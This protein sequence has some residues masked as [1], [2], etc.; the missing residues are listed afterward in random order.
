M[1][2]LIKRAGLILIFGLMVQNL[3]SQPFFGGYYQTENSFSIDEYE[4]INTVSFYLENSLNDF[5][6]FYTRLTLG[7]KF[8]ASWTAGTSLDQ[9]TFIPSL[10]LMYFEFKTGKRALEATLKKPGKGEANFDLFFFRL[11]R[12]PL[13]TDYSFLMDMNGDGMDMSFFHQNLRVRLFGITNS[14]NYMPL[15]DFADSSSRPVFTNWDR[16]RLPPLT[17]LSKDGNTSGFISDIGTDEYNFYFDNALTADYSDAEKERLNRLRVLGMFAGRVFTGVSFDLIQVY[18]QTFS[19]SFLANIDLIP[20]DFVVTFPSEISYGLNTFGGRYT[21]FY[22][23]FSAQGKIVKG[24]FYNFEGVYETGMNATLL[25]DD[26]KLFYRYDLINSFALSGGLS[27]FFEHVTRPSLSLNLR[28]AHGDEDARFVN[29]AI[30]NQS[31]QD[32]NFRSPSHE[33]ISYVMEPEFQ[34]L[35]VVELKN[36]IKPLSALKNDI[37]SRFLIE[38]GV[39]LILRPLIKGST[40]LAERPEYQEGGVSYENPEKVYLGTEIDIN[41]G[42]QF[43]SD[44]SVQLKTGLLI[45]N[46]AIYPEQEVIFKAGLIAVLSF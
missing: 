23:T 12:I 43:T 44:L 4:S 34:N 25:G 40:F 41:A 29:K 14:F 11:G 22:L 30:L 5:V 27:W 42:W 3:Q 31:G 37:F 7:V 24:F 13:K 10:D 38:S 26:S 36:T 18:S 28:Y 2:K 35:F 46:Y 15:F 21:S 6:K 45:P 33:L 19:L 9:F 17:N 32:N 16:K 39:I 20:N 1:Q 8:Y